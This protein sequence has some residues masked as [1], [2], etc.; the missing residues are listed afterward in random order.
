M[1]KIR[2]FAMGCDILACLDGDGPEVSKALNQVPGWF[3]QWEMQFSRFQPT[4]ELSL[5]NQ[6]AGSWTKVS[7]AFW[8]VLELALAGYYTSNGLVRPTMLP[9]LL[10]AGYQKS[11]D[12]LEKDQNAQPAPEKI[13]TD[14][15]QIDLNPPTRSIRMPV[16]MQ[17]DF[18]GIAKGWAAQQANQRLSD[19]G[20]ALVN[21]GGDIAVGEPLQDDQ[22]WR[23]GI[24]DPF[25]EEIDF[26]SFYIA[27][28]GVATSG[29][30][31]RRWRKNEIWQHHLIDPRTNRP[32]ESDIL[33]AT[34]FAPTVCDAEIAAKTVLMLGSREGIAWLEDQPDLYGVAVLVSK[35]TVYNSNLEKLRSVYV[36]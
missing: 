6:K 11:F 18:G 10:A 20:P 25:N 32:S 24:A 1:E 2:F 33:S 15:K 8:E 21:A 26:E 13:V 7:P 14:P 28:M 34:V 31:R 35:E 19:F 27:R 23:I 5:V 3:A 9:S 36:S 22:L 30:Y 29:T 4:S 12:L 17:L 16:G